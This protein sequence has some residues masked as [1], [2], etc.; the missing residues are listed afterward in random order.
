MA[1]VVV[2]ENVSLDGVMQAP[3]RPDEDTRGGFRHGGWGVPYSDAVYGA[4]MGKRMGRGGALL[5]GRLTYEN[6]YSVWPKRKDNPYTEVLNKTQKYVA[7]RTLQEPLPWMNSI[8]LKGDAEETVAKLKGEVGGNLAVLGSG[9]LAQTL[10]KH[11]LVD[12]LLLSIHPLT[13]GDGKRL[14]PEPGV[15]ARFKLVE[16]VPTTTGV[17]I[18]EYHAIEPNTGA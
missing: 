1:K 10:L 13:L 18:A 11:N 6:L 12:E 7:S 14:F 3:A 2:I 9:D 17:I 4:E 15:L 5:L 16:S 8:L